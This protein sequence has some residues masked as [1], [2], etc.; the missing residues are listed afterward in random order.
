MTQRK[1]WEKIDED[2]K[3]IMKRMHP[4]VLIPGYIIGFMV[5]SGCLFKIY[6]GW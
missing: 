1:H 6:M 5:I 3:E 2:N 4:A